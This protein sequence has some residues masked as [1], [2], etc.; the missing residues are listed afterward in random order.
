MPRQDGF[1]VLDWLFWHP[2]FRPMHVTV[3]SASNRPEDV[4]RARRLGADAYF[5]KPQ[6]SAELLRV[7][8]SLNDVWCSPETQKAEL[9]V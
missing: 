9:V 4:Q 8:R 3:F 6:D 1:G 2:S 7:V 5:I